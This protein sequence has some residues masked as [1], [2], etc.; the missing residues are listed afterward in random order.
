MAKQ[1]NGEESRE[2]QQTI[3]KRRFL[4]AWWWMAGEFSRKDASSKSELKWKVASRNSHVCGKQKFS[5]TCVR[6]AAKSQQNSW[7]KRRKK[8]TE[9]EHRNENTRKPP[10]GKNCL[11]IASTVVVKRE[12]SKNRRRIKLSNLHHLCDAKKR[13]NAGNSWWKVMG[14]FAWFTNGFS[15]GEIDRRLRRF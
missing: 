8:K 4:E 10:D 12:L 6:E 2:C 5:P 11:E 9:R 7:I 13:A 15:S 3:F 1:I 14:K